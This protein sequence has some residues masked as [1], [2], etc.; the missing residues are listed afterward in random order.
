[1]VG[2]NMKPAIFTILTIGSG[3]LSIMAKPTSGDL[4]DEEFSGI[5]GAGINKIVSL[6][7]SHEA[8]TLGLEEERF[9]TER[10]GM[11]FLS[12][13][14]ADRGM[15]V[16]LSEFSN[17]TRLLYT[18]MSGGLNTLVHCHGGIGRSGIVAASVLLH[19]GYRAEDAFK[20]ITQK[21]GISVPDTQEQ[22][23]WVV[24]HAAAIV[25]S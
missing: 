25:G 18:E 13:P 2:H 4:I 21:R 10:Y 6:L 14:I 22:I 1:M 19:C 15:P 20:H 5:S 7:E 24:G 3:S 12:N 23:D 16:S 8:I 11:A 9:H 17:F